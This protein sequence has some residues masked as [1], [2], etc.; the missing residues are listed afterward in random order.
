[1]TTATKTAPTDAAGERIRELNEQILDAGKKV[2]GAYLTAY[3]TALQS[4]ADFQSKAAGKT[5]DVEWL[6]TVVDAQTRFTNDM[7][8]LYVSAGRELL[9]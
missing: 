5:G 4:I 7:S 3:E 8:K 2:G 6:S 9:K 1:M